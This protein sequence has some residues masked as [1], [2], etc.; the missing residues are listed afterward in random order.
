MEV[1]IY[2]EF[3]GQIYGTKDIPI[4]ARVEGF[5]EGIHFQEGS[6]VLETERALFNVEVEHSDLQQQY[7]SSYIRLYKALGGGWLTEEEERSGEP[8]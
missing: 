3:V 2:G 1:P 4:R 6:E 8:E 5:L 7:L